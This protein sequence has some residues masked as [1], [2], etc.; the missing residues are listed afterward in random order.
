MHVILCRHGNTFRTGERI[1]WVGARTDLPLVETG[2]QQAR[3]IGSSLRANHLA[4]SRIYAGP[5]LRTK[6]TAALISSELIPPTPPITVADELREIDYGAWEG[7]TSEE[8][9]SCGGKEALA[10]W[11]LEGIWPRGFEWGPGKE[12]IL[13]NLAALVERATIENGDDSVVAFVSSNGLF[14]ILAESL[15]I[16]PASSK[17]AT[18]SMSLL[19]ARQSHLKVIGWNQK[20]HEFRV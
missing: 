10:K 12:A 17:M 1:V 15:A 7:K 9:S 16:P 18:G 6:E 3:N 2:V 11:E 20:P 13:H 5:L 19:E 8:V 14:R 4:L